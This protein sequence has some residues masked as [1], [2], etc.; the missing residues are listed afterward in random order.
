MREKAI[1]AILG[2]I[3]LVACGTGKNSLDSQAE[4][5]LI[6]NW[7]FSQGESN[8]SVYVKSGIGISKSIDAY[9]R[10]CVWVNQSSSNPWDVQLYQS[11]LNLETGKTYTLTYTAVTSMNKTANFTVKVGQSVSPYTSHGS[12]AESVTSGN[13]SN[14]SLTFIMNKSDSKAKLE[15]QLAAKNTDQYYCFD[16]I[17]LV[18]S[19]GST[20]PS[21]P[22]ETP[23][24]TPEEPKEPTMPEEPTTPGTPPTGYKANLEMIKGASVRNTN[25]DNSAYINT[26]QA[27]LPLDPNTSPLFGSRDEYVKNGEPGVAFQGVGSFRIFCEFSHF[28]YDDPLVYPGQPGAAHLHMFFGNTDVNAYSTYET[29][30]D[31]GSGTCNGLELNRTGY[32]AP[33]LFDTQGNVRVPDFIHVYYKGEGTHHGNSV[34]YPPGAAMIAKD[35]KLANNV[36]P[37]KGG[38]LNFDN[39][40]TFVCTDSWNAVFSP[41]SNTI[42]DCA[43]SPVGHRF[44]MLKMHI[45][46]PIC[47]NK[48]DASNP[49]NWFLPRDSNWYWGDCQEMAS[50][51]HLEYIIFYR[52]ELNEST[53]G[54]YLSSDVDPSTR[55]M[56][57]NSGS[58]I[59]A[60]WWGGWHPDINKQFVDNCV[61]FKDNQQKHGCGNGYLSNHGPDTSKPY[62]GPALKYRP[63][64]TGPLKVAAKTLYQ[65]LCPAGGN[66][67]STSVAAYCKPPTGSSAL[68]SHH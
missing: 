62:P 36:S 7:D 40:F 46:F 48:Q 55:K 64:Y 31:S 4:N 53:A 34:V 35:N 19:G 9:G 61:N 29:L 50:L 58:S 60:D 33:A 37:D 21:E 59:H 3:F 56:S 68:H 10:M 67:T 52:V 11:G 66:L 27:Q 57:S 16:N 54:W 51:P 39:K 6:K 65:E 38:T 15:F 47:W 12:K 49:D 26:P 14:K 43:Q 8:W 63:D 24:E 45:K 30:K 44:R 23:V 22:G 2:L 13:G 41:V 32:W 5:N 17:K 18:A 1:L 42:P 20:T 28:A 25:H